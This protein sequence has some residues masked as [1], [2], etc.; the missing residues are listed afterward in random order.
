MELLFGGTLKVFYF[1]HFLQ[2]FLDPRLVT[3]YL[4]Y[5]PCAVAWGMQFMLA[6]HLH[7]SVYTKLCTHMHFH[8]DA[9]RRRFL[10][11]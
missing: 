5:Y 10:R 7:M 3:A 2:Q 4:L 11:E 8:T 1:L 9:L 6:T